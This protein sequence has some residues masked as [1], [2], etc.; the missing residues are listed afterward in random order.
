MWGNRKVVNEAATNE[1]AGPALASLGLGYPSGLALSPG[2]LWGG[3]RSRDVP[4][5][6]S[7][8]CSHQRE[9]LV[10]LVV[11]PIMQYGELVRDL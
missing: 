5:V 8:K 3:Q 2:G 9:A 10:T 11:L 7:G 6:G 1:G 4:V